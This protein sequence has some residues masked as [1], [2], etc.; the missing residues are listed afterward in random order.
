MCSSDLIAGSKLVDGKQVTSGGRVLGVVETAET[1]GEAIDKAYAKLEEV[2]FDN[3]YFRKD[4]GTKALE[5]L[6]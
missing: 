6:K 4:I 1:L 3:M 2:H 5:A